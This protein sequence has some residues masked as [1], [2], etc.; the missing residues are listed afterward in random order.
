MK[1]GWLLRELDL[2]GDGG[3]RGLG[4]VARESITRDRER[5]QMGGGRRMPDGEEE[6]ARESSG[7]KGGLWAP[8]IQSRSVSG[9]ARTRRP[10]PPLRPQVVC[11]SNPRGPGTEAPHSGQSRSATER[12][13]VSYLSVQ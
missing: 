7:R 3:Q 6:E 1:L 8:R 2:W 10:A 4:N 11:H 9:H 5:G 13:V 12:R